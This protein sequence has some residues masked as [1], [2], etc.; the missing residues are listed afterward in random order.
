MS[1]EIEFAI[2]SP[3]DLT[4]KLDYSW[5]R[6]TLSKFEQLIN[7]DLMETQ[8]NFSFNLHLNRDLF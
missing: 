7:E 6:P 2:F 5:C 3:W 8:S 1:F 4:L